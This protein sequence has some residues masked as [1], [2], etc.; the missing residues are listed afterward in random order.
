MKIGKREGMEKWDW[1]I[2]LGQE[3]EENGCTMLLNNFKD[4]HQKIKKQRLGY[5]N[6][7]P[8]SN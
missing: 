8:R 6:H 2:I 1:G 5:T 4:L 3:M 7:R